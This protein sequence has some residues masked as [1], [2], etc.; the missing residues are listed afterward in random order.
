M[1]DVKVTIE[2]PQAAPG[3]DFLTLSLLIPVIIVFR[4]ISMF[5]RRIKK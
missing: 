4:G 1:D 2:K 3:F 5:K